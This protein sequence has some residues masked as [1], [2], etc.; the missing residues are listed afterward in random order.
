MRDK[1]ENAINRGIQALDSP[2]MSEAGAHIEAELWRLFKETAPTDTDAL[3]QIKGMQYM[4]A[5][6]LAFLNRVIQDG[7]MAKLEIER[8]PRHTAR[9]FGYS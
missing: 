1:L 7:K 5:K 4:H 3:S 6:Y 8:Q 9:E 2:L